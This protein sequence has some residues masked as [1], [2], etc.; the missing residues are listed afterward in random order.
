LQ[1]EVRHFAECIMRGER[2]LT[3]APFGLRIVEILEAAERSAER[4]GMKVELESSD[5]GSIR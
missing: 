5:A 4:D 3:G 1:Q 2:P